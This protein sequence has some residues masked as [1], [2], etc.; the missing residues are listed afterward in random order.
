[1]LLIPDDVCTTLEFG[2]L[3]PVMASENILSK[4][5]DGLS[6]KVQNYI[7]PHSFSMS[8]PIVSVSSDFSKMSPNDLNLL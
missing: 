2:S 5:S 3:E 7:L 6:C 4:L 8:C 1:M